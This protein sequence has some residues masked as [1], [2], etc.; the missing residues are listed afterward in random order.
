MHIYK[1]SFGLYKSLLHFYKPKFGLQK[2]NFHLNLTH[3]EKQLLYN[4]EK[5]SRGHTDIILCIIMK[6]GLIL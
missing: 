6:Y 1:S 4:L 2:A 3:S 5:E